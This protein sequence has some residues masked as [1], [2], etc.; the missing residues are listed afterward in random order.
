MTPR[1]TNSSVSRLRI[2]ARRTIAAL[3][4]G[5]A[6]VATGSANAVMLTS[7]GYIETFDS[8]GAAGT[9]PPADWAARIGPAGTGNTTWTTTIPG[10][11]VGAMVATAGPLT[12]TTTPSGNNNNGYNAAASPSA[13]ADRV[14]ASAPTTVSGAAWQLALT[15]GTG[16]SLTALNIAYD[17]VRYSAPATANELPGYWL[18]Y[19]VDGTNWTNV[20]SLN[21]TPAN[22]PNTAGVTA[23]TGLFSLAAA[24]APGGSLFLRWVDDNAEQTSP[25]QIIGLNNVRL[26]PVPVPAALPLLG[27]ALLGLGWITRRRRVAALG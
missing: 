11:G 16:A 7:A 19:S 6:V 12:A 21:P 2:A 5:A 4:V 26:S 18:F 27:S 1:A 17:I 3:A 8:M 9:A 24:V 25:D 22:V 10:V 15:N 20:A 14:L 13:T 23:V